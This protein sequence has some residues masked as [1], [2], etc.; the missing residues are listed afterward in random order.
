MSF[1]AHVLKLLIASPGDT[2]R[3]RDAIEQAIHDWNN[4]RAEREQIMVAP[5]R[6]ERH[7]IPELGGSAQAIIDRQAVDDC[8]V[9]LAVF[10][11]RL[12]TATDDAVS[13]TAHEI[14]RAD[15]DGKPV[16]VWFSSEPLP[17]DITPDELKRL[18]DFKRQLEA[19]ALLGSYTGVEDLQAKVR[20]A[21][22]HDLNKLDLGK[23][24]LRSRKAEQAR[25]IMNYRMSV[26]IL[27]SGTWRV[28]VHNH[29]SGPVMAI[30]VNV[31]AL[32]SDGT[33]TP[34]DVRRSKEVFSN[35]AV[36][37]S[38]ISDAMSGGFG[39]LIGQTNARMAGR[40]MTPRIREEFQDL[41]AA[42]MTDGFPSGLAPGERAVA[43]YVLPPNAS[44][45]VRVTFVDE[46]GN[47]WTRHNDE[48]PE[49]S[50][51]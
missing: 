26:S 4:A 12:G 34:H 15:S 2:G 39:P 48:E 47:R 44:P 40:A 30:N 6:W 45:V 27:G 8:D 43:L 38:V 14:L 46:A 18:Y 33:E 5:W 41:G 3:E 35:E 28:T 49:L 19:G 13:G 31:A 17:R 10:N 16:H 32:H 25:R 7:A 9:V 20:N 22:E 29:S 42:H 1:D 36:F 23:V 24:V 21:L 51:K 50:D 11:S 37:S